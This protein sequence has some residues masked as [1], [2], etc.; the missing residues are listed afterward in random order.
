MLVGAGTVLT[1]EQA[2]RA[3]AA[4][5]KFIVSPGLNPNVVKHCMSKGITVIPGCSN[6][7]DIETA[8]ELGLDTVKFFPAEAAGGIKMIR[9]MS[10]PYSGIHFVPTG[11]ID[12][13]N[14]MDYLN[15]PMVAACGGS[16][17]VSRD[18]I[19]SGA[20]DRITELVR[21]AAARML[22]FEVRHVGINASDEADAGS[23]ASGFEKTFGFSRNEGASSIFAST[24]LEIMKN[25]C[26]GANGHIAMGTNYIKRAMY[27][28]EKR[29]VRFA[30][31]TAKY[32]AQGNLK[33]IYLQEEIGGFAVHLLQK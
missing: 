20:F 16:W 12:A 18:L 5:A 2:D 7:S 23:I 15:L 31:D 3:I 29:G 30:M 10:A 9:A 13:G 26:H 21:E 25:S 28:L 24:G 32:D 27:S 11:G 4:G 33:A 1:P 6:P 17:M 8:M 22:G 14:L 19:R